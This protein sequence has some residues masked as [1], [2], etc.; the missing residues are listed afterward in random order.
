[1]STKKEG[2]EKLGTEQQK[3]ELNGLWLG[4]SLLCVPNNSKI[5]NSSLS[6]VNIFIYIFVCVCVSIARSL[7]LRI[8]RKLR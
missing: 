2:G 6:S 8:Q 3:S 4:R 1:M 7:P 5:K